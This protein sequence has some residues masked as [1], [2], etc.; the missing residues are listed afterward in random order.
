[1]GEGIF[2]GA[3]ILVLILTA[4]NARAESLAKLNEPD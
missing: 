4:S 1:M 2:M 3:L